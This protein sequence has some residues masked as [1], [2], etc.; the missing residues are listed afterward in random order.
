MLTLAF[1]RDGGTVRV[2][3]GPKGQTVSIPMADASR[4][5]GALGLPFSLADLSIAATENGDDTL[6]ADLTLISIITAFEVPVILPLD[7]TQTPADAFPAYALSTGNYASL[8]GTITSVVGQASVNGGAFSPTLTTDLVVGNTVAARVI[9]TDSAANEETWNLGAVTVSVAPIT[10]VPPVLT[11]TGTLFGRTY[12]IVGSATGTPAPTFGAIAFTANGV[13]QTLTP[14]IASG[15]YTWTYVTPSNLNPVS[16]AASVTVSSLA[17]ADIKSVSA[18]VAADLILPAVVAGWDQA[19]YVD[20][21][22]V[23]AADLVRT[24]TNPGAPVLTDGA[25]TSSLRVNGSPVSLPYTAV[26]GVSMVHR[27]SW[28]HPATG[29]TFVDSPAQVVL[30]NAWGFT[31]ELDGTGT[32]LG[33]P[34]E[35]FT[36]TLTNPPNRAGTYTRTWPTTGAAPVILQNGAISGGDRPGQTLT[37]DRDPLALALSGFSI[38][39]QWR[40]N[41]ANISGAT[42]ATYTIPGDAAPGDVFLLRHSVTDTNGTTTS[43]SNAITIAANPAAINS[44]TFSVGGVLID[45]TGSIDEALDVGG[46]FGDVNA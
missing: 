34:G 15:V 7:E 31:Q 42:A 26:A 43:D 33:I 18:T 23:T 5:V 38:S 40:K 9:V 24:I 25:L 21:E 6:T 10:P 14:S 44:V 30:S 27:V 28:T 35:D 20:G 22:S 8:A 36:I 41:G 1:E 45:Y 12:T 13:A 29:A 46:L 17:G 4:L 37:E 32:F 2:T 16:L 3:V 11:L 39:R 19:T